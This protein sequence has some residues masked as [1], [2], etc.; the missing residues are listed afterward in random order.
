MHIILGASGQVGSGIIDQLIREKKP[1]KG[2]IRNPEKARELRKKGA[3]LAIADAFDLAALQAAFKGGT[4]VFVFTPESIHSEDLIGDTK[5]ILENYRKAIESS[6]I[7]KIV[8]LSSCGAQHTSGTGNLKQSYMLEH[9]F[10]GM[11]VQQVFIRPAYYYSNWLPYLP[12][13]KEQGVLPTFFPSDLKIPMVSPHD[14][15]QFVAGVMGKPVEGAAIYELEGPGDYSS[16]DVAQTLGQVLDREVKAE[17]IPREGW[18]EALQQAGFSADVMKNFI[19]MTEAVISGLAKP[20]RKGT[21]AVRAQ[22]TLKQYMEAL[23]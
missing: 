17:Q 21:I 13:V 15:A 9:A 22:T 12:T 11:S 1:V 2:V 8:G 6:P 14:V 3:E 16:N 4:T 23:A 20:E 19:E 5:V 10:M 7:K 18:E